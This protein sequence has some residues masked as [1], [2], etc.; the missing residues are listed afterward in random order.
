MARTVRGIMGPILVPRTSMWLVA[1]ERADTRRRKMIPWSVP[2]EMMSLSPSK[3]RASDRSDPV[4]QRDGEDTLVGDVDLIESAVARA[5]E[6]NLA[7]PRMGPRDRNGYLS[8][9]TYA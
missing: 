7:L 5:D 2:T 4:A 8:L 1:T 6:H 9:D 3:V